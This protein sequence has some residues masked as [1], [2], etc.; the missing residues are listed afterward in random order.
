M[1]KIG[2]NQ[3]C[4]CGSGKKYKHCC[5]PLVQT[6]QPVAPE[7]VQ[8]TS[9]SLR[10]EVEKLQ[11]AAEKKQKLFFESGVFIL[12][13][14]E[15]GDGWLL[16][17][18]ESDAVQVVRAGKP[19]D[20]DLVENTET[21]EVN[22]SHTYE[23]RDRRFFLTAYSDGN[24]IELRDAPCQQIRAG[25]RRIQQRY[26]PEVL[27]MIHLD[28]ENGETKNVDSD[29]MEIENAARNDVRPAAD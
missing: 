15:N 12:F 19:I 4:P 20:I 16:E 23:L 2:R 26:T 22:W 13:T 6:G 9:F 3:P 8:P 14:D 29:T 25:I 11:A 27:G 18:V 17:V 28:T 10:T 7:M 1:A 5:L 24:Q 21:I